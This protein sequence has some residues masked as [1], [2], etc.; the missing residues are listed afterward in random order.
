MKRFAQREVLQAVEYAKA[1]GQALHVFDGAIA[2]AYRDAPQCFRG[3][4]IVAHLFDQD[5]RRLCSTARRLGVRV[6]AVEYQGQDRQHIDLCGKPLDNAL[7]R[8]E[9]F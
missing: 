9:L 4:Q 1:G 7:D 3:R 5:L 6:I 8:C 2:D